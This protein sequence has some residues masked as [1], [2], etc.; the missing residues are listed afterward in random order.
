M[1]PAE[2]QQLLRWLAWSLK[3]LRENGPGL[4]PFSKFHPSQLEASRLRTSCRL[5]ISCVAFQ[6]RKPRVRKY[7]LTR[8]IVGQLREF[9]VTPRID[10]PVR[11]LPPEGVPLLVQQFVQQGGRLPGR[12]D[13]RIRNRGQ[14]A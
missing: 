13:V 1:R 9:P 11:A 12:G 5:G 4:G 10:P 14:P 7:D 3:F 8:L 2:T 6:I